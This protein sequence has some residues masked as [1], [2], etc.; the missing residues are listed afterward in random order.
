MKFKVWSSDCLTF[1]RIIVS[2]IYIFDDATERKAS[3]APTI[4]VFGIGGDFLFVQY[5]TK[6]ITSCPQETRNG[7]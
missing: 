6:W 7:L 2:Y 1:I 4:E 3:I 5:P